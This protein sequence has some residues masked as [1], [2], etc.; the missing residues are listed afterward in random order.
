MLKHVLQTTNLTKMSSLITGSFLP[1]A[2][3]KKWDTARE[4]AKYDTFAYKGLKFSSPTQELVYALAN[5][6][7][8]TKCTQH[9]PLAY[10]VGNTS[11]SD[12][13]DKDGYRLRRPECS[14]CT[15]AANVGK[16]VAK[17][18][19]K[20]NNIPYKAPS[21]TTCAVCGCEPKRGNGLFFDHC[22]KKELFRGYACNSCNRSMG[23]L[24]DD[25]AGMLKVIN[26]LN[27]TEKVKFYQDEGGNLHIA[28]D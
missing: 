24:G 5:N 1:P 26:Y 14:D 23:V 4:R 7:Q 13:F 12:P 16:N 10:F 18:I 9:K 3:L 22:H 17:R 8:C 11:G 28:T 2:L 19:A 27:K 21:G 6:K 15:K 20:K 25:I